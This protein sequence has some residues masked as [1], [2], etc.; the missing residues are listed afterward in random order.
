[1][2]TDPRV[3]L[4]AFVAALER[5][6][7]VVA[8]RRGE[9]DPAVEAAY[10]S[11]AEAFDEYDRAL[12]DTYGEVTPFEIYDDEDDDDLDDEDDIEE[13]DEELDDADDDD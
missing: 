2:A 7:E 11:L 12:M 10:Q 8:A 9:Q 5:H 1:M 3:A 4:A 13:L 6:F